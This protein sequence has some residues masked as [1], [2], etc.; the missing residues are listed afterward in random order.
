MGIQA[1]S[2]YRPRTSA[3]FPS[4]MLAIGNFAAGVQ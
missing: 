4:K 3:D 1:G 2:F